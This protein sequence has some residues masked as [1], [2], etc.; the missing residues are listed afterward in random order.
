[1]PYKGIPKKYWDKLDRCVQKVLNSPSFQKTYRRRRDK[2]MSKK[3]L[4][5]AI[6]RK[7]LKI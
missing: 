5:V 6:C 7:T 2:K 3:S 4:A 1:M